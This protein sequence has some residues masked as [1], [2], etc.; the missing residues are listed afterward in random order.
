MQETCKWDIQTSCLSPY[1]DPAAINS[2][3]TIINSMSDLSTVQCLKVY[4]IL[5]KYSSFEVHTFNE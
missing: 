5:N 2:N 3:I 1:A 4:G